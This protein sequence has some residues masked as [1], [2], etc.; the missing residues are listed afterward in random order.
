MATSTNIKTPFGFENSTTHSAANFIKDFTEYAEAMCWSEFQR[1]VAFKL[2]LTGEAQLWIRSIS[3]EL[4]FETLK[5]RFTERFTP[6]NTTL[7]AIRKLSD[8]R[9]DKTE[10][11]LSFLDKM[12]YIAI[13]GGLTHD[14]LLAMT[15]KAL[16][17]EIGNKLIMVP[18]GLTWE[19]IYSLCGIWDSMGV[20][21]EQKES[22]IWSMRRKPMIRERQRYRSKDI[23]CYFCDNVGHRIAECRKLKDLKEREKRKIIAEANSMN[24]DNPEEKTEE[25]NNFKYFSFSTSINSKLPEIKIQLPTGINVWATL[26]TGSDVSLI[27]I[28]NAR[29]MKYS[30]TNIKV[31]GANNTRIDV[32]G[33]C[34]NTIVI[35]KGKKQIVDMVVCNE[36]NRPCIL[37]QDFL[38]ANKVTLSFNT[39]G[40]EIVLSCKTLKAQENDAIGVHRI[41]TGTAAPIAVAAYR[42]GPKLDE[43]INKQVKE[44]LRDGIIRPSC[45]PWRAPVVMVPKKESGKLRMCI[46]YRKLNDVTIKDSYP[47]PNVQEVLDAMA[48]AKVYSKMDALSGYH[49]VKI[50]DEDIEKTAFACKLGTFEFVRMPFGLV[51]A[52]AT[53]QRLMD[54]A[55]REE[56][57]KFVVVYLDDV[58]V[59]S[60]S[61][62]EHKIH[63]KIIQDKLKKLGMTFNT[64]KCEFFKKEIKILGHI[65]SKRGI[66]PD[67]NRV[68]AIKE[69]RNPASKKELMSFLGLINYCRKFI[70]KLSVR[71]KPLYDLLKKE[72][73]KE[74]LKAK[75]ASED[76]AYNI[77]TL[78]DS[79]AEDA[80]L[81]L[82]TQT[83]KFILT[84]DASGV[85]VGAVL[86]QIQ[87]GQERV[88]EYFS[89]IHNN[90]QKGY[91]T[92]EQEL[93]AVISAIEHF[94]PYLYGRP[95]LIRT[96]H[97]AILYLLKSKGTKA[98]LMR[99]ALALQ[100]YNFTVEHLKG[101]ENFSDLL[102]RAFTSTSIKIERGG[103]QLTI[104]KQEDEIKILE[105]YHTMTGHGGLGTMK[106]QILTKY[107]FRGANKKINRFVDECEI[108]EKMKRKKKV[109]SL[110]P[111]NRQR[112]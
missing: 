48:G 81:V 3:S 53:F 70:P 55:L 47:V 31:Y 101:T 97:K 95:F 8:S 39:H 30:T 56:L 88:I 23:K 62:E 15:L 100:E 69:F 6:K 10:S 102:S 72:I 11:I 13:E 16:P 90:A 84:T 51:N 5:E 58:I 32:V 17:P 94:R 87:A 112:E 45:S 68:K 96:D 103:R 33:V 27:S 37:G 7:T 80:L 46:D 82:P 22:Q 25:L 41:D 106:Y 36:L 19:T 38:K 77:Q 50:Q 89:S 40:C 71:S 65:V 35:H 43:V 86:S 42:Q 63:V 29:G 12:N 76:T 79:I 83:G 4:D 107:W 14:V 24:T 57:W 104:P 18:G 91:S 73:P 67:P 54:N 93:L 74:E 9:W 44:Y 105:Q 108:C 1:K 26:D 21:N 111:N 28:E 109:K 61:E 34:R 85:G 98:R 78:K 60:K 2:A 49:Q 75:L 110:Y 52:P 99:W 92:T 64:E 59:Y 20:L 66:R